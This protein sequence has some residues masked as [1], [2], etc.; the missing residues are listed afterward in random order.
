MAKYTYKAPKHI[1]G[2][3]VTTKTHFGTTGDMIV[4]HSSL[5]FENNPIIENNQIVCKDDNG[6]YITFKNRVDSGLADPNRYANAK[7]RLFV[8]KPV[9]ETIKNGGNDVNNVE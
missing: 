4:D 5:V 2:S 7:S 8:A 6:Y 1:T 3:A 9:E